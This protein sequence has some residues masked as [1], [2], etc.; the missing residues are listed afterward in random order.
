MAKGPSN[1]GMTVSPC[2]VPSRE[3]SSQLSCILSRNKP[4][5]AVSLPPW[6]ES[7]PSGKNA[8]NPSELFSNLER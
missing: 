4:N 3:S 1:S 5:L 2:N 7:E 8:D 6:P